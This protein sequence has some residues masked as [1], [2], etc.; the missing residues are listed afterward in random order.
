MSTKSDEKPNQTLLIIAVAV[1][2][3]L[4]WTGQIDLERILPRPKPT[5]DAPSVPEIPSITERQAP[6]GATLAPAQALRAK[7]AGAAAKAAAIEAHYAGLAELLRGPGGERV[8]TMTQ[9][10]AGHQQGLLLINAR[11]GLATPEIGAEI[12]AVLSAAAG[13]DPGAIDAS[14]RSQLAIGC[15]AIAWACWAARNGG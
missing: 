15:D 4:I 11:P 12:D 5:P 6:T 3:Y 14:R 2:G 1:I 9:F 10:R 8:A 7:L 13:L